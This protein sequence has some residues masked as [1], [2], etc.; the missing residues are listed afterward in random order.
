MGT[1]EALES[2][3][4]AHLRAKLVPVTFMLLT[5]TFLPPL[6]YF[7]KFASLSAG[8]A[9]ASGMLVALASGFPMFLK[10]SLFR[11]FLLFVVIA[12]GMLMH[13]V[14]AGLFLEIDY[15][16]ATGSLL[17]LMAVMVGGVIFANAL[18]VSENAHVAR[19]LRVC[20]ILFCIFSALALIGIIVPAPASFSYVKSVFPFTEPSFF[21]LSFMSVFMATSV[22]A[23]GY[24][25]GLCL[26]VGLLIALQ[27]QNLTMLVGW[28][29]V[30]IVCTRGL[31]LP[32]AFMALAG[33]ASLLDLT[34]Y[35]AR[36][37][38]GGTSN[39]ISALV[40]IQGWQLLWDGM[41]TSQ[42]WGIG[43]QQLG[44]HGV[45]T[46]ISNTIFAI[47]GNNSNTL[48]GGFVLAKLGG[49]FGIFGL[50]AAA[51][52]LVSAAVCARRLSKAAHKRADFSSAQIFAFSVL[53]T[54]PVELLV[55]GVGYFTPTAALL[56]AALSIMFSNRP[57]KAP[58]AK[59]VMHGALRNADL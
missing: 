56:V 31:I 33:L 57:Q 53:A 25:R 14:F 17:L 8:S 54:Y 47:L 30:T 27:L 21:A 28:L 40:Y 20:F 52:L 46:E 7:L 59:A 5:L 42:G 13:L 55:R 43:F 38:F 4:R 18:T 1:E 2:T 32:F 34:Y 39:N 9:L 41:Q 51:I 6:I 26:L 50:V 12:V 49:E 24:A 10:K 16:R 11:S 37:S 36:L 48:D 23:R 44:V 35:T 19:A 3:K 45:Y 22:L 15:G 29:M 58:A